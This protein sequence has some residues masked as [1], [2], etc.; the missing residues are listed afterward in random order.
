VTGTIRDYTTLSGMLME[1]INNLCFAG[2]SASVLPLDW[3]IFEPFC[4]A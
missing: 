1:K 2:I 4:L 3:F